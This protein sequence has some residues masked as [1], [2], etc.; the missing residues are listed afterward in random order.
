MFDNF[1]YVCKKMY[2]VMYNVYIFT[3]FG[4]PLV[5]FCLLVILINMFKLNNLEMAFM[6]RG[7]YSSLLLLTAHKTCTSTHKRPLVGNGEIIRNYY[8]KTLFHS[9]K[10][11]IHNVCGICGSRFLEE[12]IDDV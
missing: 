7:L 2:N 5:S 12:M 3:C 8:N 6:V 10:D 9:D 1:S 4:E 11:Y